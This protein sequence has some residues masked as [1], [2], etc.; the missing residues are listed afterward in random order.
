VLEYLHADHQV[1]WFRWDVV[2]CVADPIDVRA[3]VEV[4]RLVLGAGEQGAGGTVDI[5]AADLDNTG[6]ML[7]TD[8]GGGELIRARVHVRS[9]PE[10]GR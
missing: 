3:V 9:T 8:R 7:T 4:E 2:E 5:A 1:D 10:L 6:E